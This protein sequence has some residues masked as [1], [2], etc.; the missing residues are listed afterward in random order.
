MKEFKLAFWTPGT[1]L[2]QD[3]QLFGCASHGF[4]T[5]SDWVEP[6]KGR[7][8]LWEETIKGTVFSG[9]NDSVL[10]NLGN[11]SFTPK[12]CIAFFRKPLGVE[13]F[14]LKFRELLPNVPVIG[15]GAAI[16]E[17][18]NMGDVLPLAE[19]VVLLAAAEGEFDLQTLN[20]YNQTNMELEINKTSD[21]GFDKVRLLPDGK[22]QS[23]LDFFHEQKE[24]RGITQDDFE[25]ITFHDLNRR[26]IHCSIKEDQILTGANLP[27]NGRLVLCVVDRKEATRH[28][29]EF[30]SEERS[31][32]IGCAGI[33]S[34]VQEPLTTGRGSLAG[35]LFGEVVSFNNQPMFGN[36]M[37]A[38]LTRK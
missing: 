24:I 21:R 20:I 17:G 32:V 6:V 16:G 8:S 15:G 4:A 13:H 31:L 3:Q 36:L 38:R 26:N 9:G 2:L 33:R 7:Y 14:I 28:L 29:S 27:D 1:G 30:I 19:E 25:S 11:C 10:T 5:D 18:Q 34:L 37:L 22:W 12:V 35:F 23:A